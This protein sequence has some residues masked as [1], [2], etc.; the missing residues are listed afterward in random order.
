[1][2]HTTL[3]CVIVAVVRM[4][5]NYFSLTKLI[6]IFLFFFFFFLKFS[7]TRLSSAV[8]ALLLKIRATTGCQQESEYY[9]AFSVIIIVRIL[10]ENIAVRRSS[11]Q[12]CNN[13]LYDI[14]NGVFRL[15]V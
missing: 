3:L 4:T 13:N 8:A 2:Y 10:Y 12:Y 14:D 7:I 1:M 9:A 5:E 15:R 11:L 6:R